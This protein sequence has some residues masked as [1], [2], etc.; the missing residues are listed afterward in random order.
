MSYCDFLTQLL[1]FLIY[2]RK[3]IFDNPKNEVA[4]MMIYSQELK[5]CSMILKNAVKSDSSDHDT[6]KCSTLDNDFNDINPSVLKDQT[7]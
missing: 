2:V 4:K 7:K 3:N 5:K 6:E 1:I